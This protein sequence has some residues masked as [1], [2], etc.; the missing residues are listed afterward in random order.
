MDP[1]DISLQ[2]HITPTCQQDLSRERSRVKFNFS[3]SLR[4]QIV[5]NKARMAC[6]PLGSLGR[7]VIQEKTGFSTLAASVTATTSKWT[8]ACRLPSPSGQLQEE[9]SRR[10]VGHSSGATHQ[11]WPRQAASSFDPRILQFC[12]DVRQRQDKALRFQLA[13]STAVVSWRHQIARLVIE[14]CQICSAQPGLAHRSHH[15]LSKVLICEA[16]SQVLIDL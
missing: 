12:Q 15:G 5:Q 11:P 1:F 7:G 3:T 2:E 4:G 6:G 13:V 14:F 8:K 16:G 10:S 9:V